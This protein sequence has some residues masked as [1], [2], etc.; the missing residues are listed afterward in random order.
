M[1]GGVRPQFPAYD[2]EEQMDGVSCGD[3]DADAPFQGQIRESFDV[4]PHSSHKAKTTS[5]D[6]SVYFLESGRLTLEYDTREDLL[7][8]LTE[9]TET[10]RN[11][12]WKKTP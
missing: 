11:R 6:D 4:V 2:C 3:D 9:L 8:I 5:F 12:T 10:I 7:R 1:D